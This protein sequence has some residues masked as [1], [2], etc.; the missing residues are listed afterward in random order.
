[1]ARSRPVAEL[2][3]AHSWSLATDTCKPTERQPHM[4]YRAK[5]ID[6]LVGMQNQMIRM[7]TDDATSLRAAGLALVSRS[8]YAIGEYD[9]HHRM[10]LA[11]AE[12]LRVV[13][14]EGGRGK[15]H[16]GES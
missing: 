1:M 4:F 16:K 14:D 11:A 9:G 8:A 6:D 10:A 12:F 3:R 13:A 5:D 15:R 2:Y 7:L